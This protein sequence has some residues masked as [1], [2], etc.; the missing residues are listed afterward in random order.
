MQDPERAHIVGVVNS[1][2]NE[3]SD[4]PSALRPRSSSDLTGIRD[5]EP[6]A[7]LSK[8]P[9]VDEFSCFGSEVVFGTK[10]LGH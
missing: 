8:K 5:H 2:V 4:G 3:S 1:F 10:K 6:I 7:D 9:S